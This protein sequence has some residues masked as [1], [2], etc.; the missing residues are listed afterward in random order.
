MKVEREA[1][2]QSTGDI[3][4]RA[5]PRAPLREHANLWQVVRVGQLL[6]EQIREGSGRLADGESRMPAA[7]DENG[8]LPAAAECER[9][10]RSGEAG[11]DDGDV[12]VNAHWLPRD[13][14]G[15][16]G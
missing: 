16:S 6:E 12:G 4:T 2:L 3:R 14:G 13:R 9:H 10:E 1:A 7:L 11:A 8:A 15:S 5:L